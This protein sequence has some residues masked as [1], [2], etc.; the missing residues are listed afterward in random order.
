MTGPKVQITGRRVNNFGSAKKSLR[1]KAGI[2]FACVMSSI[3][4]GQFNV[5][6]VFPAAIDDGAL[7]PGSS[8]QSESAACLLLCCNSHLPAISLDQFPDHVFN[9]LGS[10]SHGAPYSIVDRIKRVLAARRHG[11]YSFLTCAVQP[12]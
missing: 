12:Q 10:H 11:A 1:E 2:R 9:A 6:A 4:L 5:G 7:D 8:K 3:V